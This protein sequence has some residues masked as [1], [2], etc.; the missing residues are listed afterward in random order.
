MLSTRKK[1]DERK[2]VNYSWK[3]Q[4][5]KEEYYEKKR[6]NRNTPGDYSEKNTNE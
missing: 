4:K 6:K 5:E 2:K 1:S 3:E